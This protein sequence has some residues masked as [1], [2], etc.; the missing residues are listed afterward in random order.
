MQGCVMLCIQSVTGYTTSDSET[1]DH[2]H[3]ACK[4]ILPRVPAGLDHQSAGWQQRNADDKVNQQLDDH[5]RVLMQT[6]S[7]QSHKTDAGVT[8]GCAAEGTCN[9]SRTSTVSHACAVE[10]G[11]LCK[12]EQ[13]SGNSNPPS[14]A[15]AP[16]HDAEAW[17]L[18][19]PSPLGDESPMSTH[20]APQD[21]LLDSSRTP[22]GSRN[23]SP[24]GWKWSPLWQ[25]MYRSI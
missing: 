24:S 5:I 7:P 16:H 14:A 1:C 21:P 2:K 10:S 22:V 8:G 9:R 23:Q 19:T 17:Q 25:S 18:P 12:S 15:R 3:G 20:P 6:L 13:Q 11:R 4:D